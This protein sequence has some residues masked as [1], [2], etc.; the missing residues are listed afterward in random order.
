MPGGAPITTVPTTRLGANVRARRE[1]LGWSQGD[2][3]R[4]A[5][6]S[7][8]TISVCEKGVRMADPSASI[9]YRIALALGVT[10][11]DLM[12]VQP[13]RKT[14]KNVVRRRAKPPESGEASSTA[15]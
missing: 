13:L 12:G 15:A 1:D 4:A 2:L 3:S 11:E 14:T 5:G 10:M 6:L 9:L 7:R 8:S